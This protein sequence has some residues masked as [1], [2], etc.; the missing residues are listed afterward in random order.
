M[1]PPG[2]FLQPGDA[3]KSPPPKLPP[4]T[5]EP[6]DQAVTR[7]RNGLLLLA[8]AVL[9]QWIPVVEYLG[10]VVG[11]VGAIL[12]ILG[13]RPFGDRHGILVGTSV[14]LFIAA[15]ILE[16]LLVFSFAS[17][18]T[19]IGG[20]GSAA[21]NA[22]L[23]AWSGLED[24]LLVAVSLTS[25]SFALI[26][27]A[28]EDWPGR[29]L[30]AAAVA[31]QIVI[32]VGILVL[33][34]DPILRVAVT[35]AFASTPVDLSVIE[36]ADAQISGLGALRV[37]NAIPAVLFA[38]AYVWAHD[39]IGRGAVPPSARP[40]RPPSRTLA[41]LLVAVVVLAPAG[42][43]AAVATGALRGTPA[44]LPSPPTWRLVTQFNGTGPE[45]TP[46][47][48]LNGTRSEIN[49]TLTSY[50]GNAY[51]AYSVYRA[52]DG[53]LVGSCGG[54][55][56]DFACGGPDLPGTYDLVVTNTTGVATWTLVVWQY[57]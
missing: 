34:V 8:V 9:L 29:L 23:G 4:Q 2:P 43:I 54:T 52:G 3:G 15:L 19:S 47:F 40:A 49:T 38:A 55:A 6:S 24:G 50:A 18:L 27:A 1:L 35:R 39:R 11:A 30:L 7:T 41:A 28:L 22:F 33:V 45:T 37:L 51:F 14:S 5:P 16:L 31:A 53:V 32:S 56:L 12:M 42:G 20:T 17:S 57:A 13:R 25:V 10:L 46:T 48:R 36:A 21:A 44:P 26:A